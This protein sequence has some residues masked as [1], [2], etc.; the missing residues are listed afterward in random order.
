MMRYWKTVLRDSK[1]GV[2]DRTSWRARGILVLATLIG[3]SFAV[4]P[5]S[6]AAAACTSPTFSVYPGS[7]YS[8]VRYGRVDFH[9]VACSD[10]SPSG[11][12]ASVTQ[13][14]VNATG[15]N[16]GFFINST[17][18]STDSIG[19]SSRWWTGN[20]YASTCTP[21]V[22]FPCSRSY[23]FHVQFN[24]SYDRNGNVQIYMGTRTAPVGMALF[25]TP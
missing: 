15:Q 5:A 8:N 11:W 23:S 1:S 6:P 9:F 2:G 20:I 18:I 10:Q 24:G 13:A 3:L 4:V 21:R 16:L 14:T 22:G 17:S 25:T 12:S 19:S 7:A